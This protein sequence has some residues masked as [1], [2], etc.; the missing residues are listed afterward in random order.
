MLGIDW[1]TEDGEDGEVRVDDPQSAWRLTHFRCET[2]YRWER[3]DTLYM[4]RP[5]LAIVCPNYLR[6]SCVDFAEVVSLK[7]NFHLS[8]SL[9]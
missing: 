1:E 2:I 3:E 5:M 7:N 6:V 4:D 9:S 8:L